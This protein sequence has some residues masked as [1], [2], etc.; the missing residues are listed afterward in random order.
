MYVLSA[1]T[2]HI[3]SRQENTLAAWIQTGEDGSGYVRHYMLD[4]GDCFGIIHPWDDLV[5]R[6]GHSGYTDLQHVVEDLLTLGLL[7]R[8]WFDARYGIAGDTLGYYDARRFV[9]DQWRPGYGNNAYERATEADKAWMARIIARFRDPHIRATVATG[10]FLDENVSNELGRILIGRRDRILERWL[11][12]LSPLVWP[13]QREEDGASEVCMQDLAVWSDIRGA[14]RRRYV[15]NAY[16][17]SAHGDLEPIDAAEPVVR[18]DAVVCTPLPEV[19]GAT[20]EAPAYLVLDVVASS[21]G[22]ETSGPARLHFYV[23]GDGTYD[24]VGLERPHDATPP[25]N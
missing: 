22:R 9:A 2:D 13:M 23:D 14:S 20:A 7:D 15:A 1:W 8:P 12:R 24:L 4:F 3:D 6:F 16:A 25:G 21:E 5:R 18:A 10:Q 17:G 19:A 11:T